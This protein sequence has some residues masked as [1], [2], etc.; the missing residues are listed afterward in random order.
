MSLACLIAEL[1]D[2]KDD[3]AAFRLGSGR[4]GGAKAS[5]L[6]ACN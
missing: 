2:Y 6:L 4:V 3:G 5:L 1:E